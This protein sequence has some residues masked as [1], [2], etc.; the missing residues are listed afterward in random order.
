MEVGALTT[1]TDDTSTTSSSNSPTKV[2]A[3]H[4]ETEAPAGFVS[5]AWCALVHRPIP[6]RE[7]RRINQ[8]S[9]SID[10]EFN[11]LDSRGFV[12][13]DSVK[14][15]WKA[16]EDAKEKHART[17]EVTHFGDLMTLCHEKHAEL[18]RPDHLKEYK[19][20]IVF[21]GDKGKDMEGY[22]AVFSEQ[23]TSASHLEAAKMMD[24]LA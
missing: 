20:R 15:K 5:D 21:R 2:G 24:A 8:A 4:Q 10:K 1:T 9:K 17:G 7:A 16:Q 13:W 19:G 11:K 12:E 23:G 6:L 18:S 22:L 14:E 3:I